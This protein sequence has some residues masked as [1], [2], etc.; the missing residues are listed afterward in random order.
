MDA[1]AE[2]E[3]IA[4]NRPLRHVG[5][6]LLIVL[7]LTEITDGAE[8]GLGSVIVVNCGRVVLVEL[9]FIGDVVFARRE[10]L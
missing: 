1:L 7:G 6:H 4:C 9:G 8:L 2:G 5:S 10:V 3:V